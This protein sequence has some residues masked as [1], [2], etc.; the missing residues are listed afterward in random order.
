M[1]AEISGTKLVDTR[2]IIEINAKTTREV[3]LVRKIFSRCLKGPLGR[4]KCPL[5]EFSDGALADEICGDVLLLSDHDPLAWPS[6]TF[7]CR[8]YSGE[9]RDVINL[10]LRVLSKCV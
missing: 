7:Q 10:F 4:V 3:I 6:G 9:M 8:S 2:E 5:V 1:S